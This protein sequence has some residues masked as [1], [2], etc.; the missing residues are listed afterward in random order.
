MLPGFPNPLPAVY[1]D[2][3][4]VISISDAATLAV[5]DVYSAFER[6]TGSKLNLGKC[7]GLWLGSWRNHCDSPVPILWNSTKI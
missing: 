4:S 2:D 5:F 3:T 1:V 6:G 7:E